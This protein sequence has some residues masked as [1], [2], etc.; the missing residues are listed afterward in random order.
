MST[1]IAV[2]TSKTS[3]K[4]QTLPIP[5]PGPN[6]V[7]V[8]NVVVA[9]NPKDYKLPFVIP[10]YEFV[11]GSDVA[12][13]VEK[14][15]EGVTEY[16]GG[17]R[18]AAFTKMAT[19][20]NKYGAYQQYSLAVASCAFPIP[21]SISFEDASTL[22]LAVMT[23]S[24]GL[25]I[26]L[27]LPEPPA[28][29]VATSAP[30]QVVVINGASS[31]VGAYAVQ[32]AKRA[33]LFVVGIAGGS[34][35]YA[36]SLG[37]DVVVDYRGYKGKGALQAAVTDAVLET[38]LPCS[39]ALD[40][41]SE[42]GTIS[43]LAGVVASTSPTGGGKVNYLGMLSD[44]EKNSLPPTVTAVRT[45]VFTAYGEHQ[46][47]ASRFYRQIS[48][49]LVKSDTN[50]KPLLPN[51]VHVVP[52]GLAG[53]EK[54]LAMLKAHEVHAEKLVYKIGDSPSSV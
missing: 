21:E 13:Y 24:L 29:G 20:D 48:E 5:E 15:G 52:G 33:G 41:V 44:E 46:A 54:G 23:A 49:Y 9:S 26:H 47:F 4:L 17:E 11:E 31:S 19:K 35:A 16:K 53:V 45:A 10:G 37:A 51:K 43:E 40:C 3:S 38:G 28:K 42:G 30:T 1:Q 2:V 34:G 36:E 8:K 39:S 22:P 7:L 50:P 18:V 6:E 14:V 25:F 32:L 27:G 12:G